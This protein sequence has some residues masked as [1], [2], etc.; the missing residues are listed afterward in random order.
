MLSH[1]QENNRDTRCVHHADQCAYHV[2]HRV[3]FRDDEAVHA[4]AVVAELAL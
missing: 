3:A 2:A 4:Y 1:A